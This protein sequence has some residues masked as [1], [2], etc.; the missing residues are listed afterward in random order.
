MTR[1]AAMG[2]GTSIWRAGLADPHLHWK[3]GRSAW[4]LAVSWEAQR[5]SDSGLPPEVQAVF[6]AHPDFSAP[7]LLIG[8]VEHL[9]TL[10]TAKT[11]SQNDL[12]CAIRATSGQVSV[13]IEGKAGEEFDKTLEEWLEGDRGTKQRRLS[14]LCEHLGIDS[15]PPHSLRYQLFH[16]AASAILEA[17]RW[18]M[19][20][21]LMLVQSFGESKTA[22]SDFAAFCGH[23]GLTVE[24]GRIAGPRS[25]GEISFYAG[26]VDSPPATDQQAAA[27]V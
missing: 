26:W 25:L 21:A 1:I 3:R 4:E 2:L 16:R 14:F 12:W 11:P 7:T 24:R 20:R 17:R 22:W 27:A 19:P 13:A 23:V 10:D 18:R 15:T 8:L 9:V 5:R 6:E